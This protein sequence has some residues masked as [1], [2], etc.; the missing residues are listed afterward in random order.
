MVGFREFIADFRLSEEVAGR[1][2][3]FARVKAPE[4]E[5]RT[6]FDGVCEVVKVVE[7]FYSCDR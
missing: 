6:L 3:D 4:V 5:Q 2:F 1:V 7:K